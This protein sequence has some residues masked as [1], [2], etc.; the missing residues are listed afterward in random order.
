MAVLVDKLSRWSA[1]VSAA[2]AAGVYVIWMYHGASPIDKVGSGFVDPF[3]QFIEPF[4][5]VVLSIV[6]ATGL[7]MS[8]MALILLTRGS[9]IQ[10]G[11]PL[12]LAFGWMSLATAYIFFLWAVPPFVEFKPD[13]TVVNVLL[14]SG[15]GLALAFGIR[16]FIRFWLRFPRPLVSDDLLSSRLLFGSP[17][18]WDEVRILPAS[19]L[20]RYYELDSA[21][22]S[23]RVPLAS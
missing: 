2:L 15:C 5:R 12:G 20:R 16:E 17:E 23:Y 14:D 11:K 21:P 7:L 22:F 19:V 3:I 8:V 9:A 10:S 4:G 1:I 13:S 18:G 6:A